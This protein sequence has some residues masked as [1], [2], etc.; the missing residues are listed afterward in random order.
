MEN[1]EQSIKAEI[2]NMI[3]RQMEYRARLPM[4]TVLYGTDL[5]DRAQKVHGDNLQAHALA[6]EKKQYYL[7]QYE[8]DMETQERIARDI[9]YICGI[10]HDRPN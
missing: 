1:H 2:K 8:G 10:T 3:T 7:P 9:D 4:L 5:V 6:E